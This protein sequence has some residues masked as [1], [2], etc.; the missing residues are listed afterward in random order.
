[1][2]VVM[3]DTKPSRVIDREKRAG[4]RHVPITGGPSPMPWRW[5]QP[6]IACLLASR[7]KRSH[8]YKPGNWW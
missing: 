3:G 1:M 7:V 4:D 5:M 8:I 2:F 6:I